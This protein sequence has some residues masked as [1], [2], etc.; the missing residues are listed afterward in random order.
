[1]NINHEKEYNKI[2]PFAGS[3][4]ST[5]R[6]SL[7]DFSWDLVEEEKSLLKTYVFFI[8]W[9]IMVIVA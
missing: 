5:F 8:V 6:L 7:G 3:I 9:F 2:T 4:L 1:M